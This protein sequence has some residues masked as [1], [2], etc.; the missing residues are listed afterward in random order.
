[1]VDR[2]TL[3]QTMHDDKTTLSRAMAQN[4]QLKEQLIEL[5]DGFVRMVSP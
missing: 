3:L 5:Q 1:M 2:E 4:K